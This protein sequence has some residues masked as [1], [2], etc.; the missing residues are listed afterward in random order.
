MAK[1][2]DEI[3]KLCHKRFKWWSDFESHNI[4]LFKGDLKFANG[5]SDNKWQWSQDNQAAR[6]NKP[7]LTVNKISQHNRQITNEARQNKPCIKYLPVDSG[8]DVKTAEILNGLVRHVEA[9]SNADLAYDT[10][11]EFAVDAG[12]GYWYIDTDYID[13]KTFDQEI[14]INTIDN[15]LNV[16]L[17]HRP[18]YAQDGSDAKWGMLFY[19]MPIDE[20]KDTYPKAKDEQG[21]E[22]GEVVENGWQDEKTIRL[23]K[24]YY[25][26]Y[27]DD[28][29]LANEQGILA[30][31]SDLKDAPPELIKGA[32]K[33]RKIRKPKITQ[34]L[35][36]GKTILETTVWPGKYIP[37]VRIVGSEKVIENKFERKGHTRPMKDP[38]VM[39]NYWTSAATEFVSMQGKQPYLAAYESI[40]GLEQYWSDMDTSNKPVLPFRAWDDEG[41]QLPMPKRQDPPI[42]A[43]AYIDGMQVASDEMK[44]TSGQYDATFGKNPNQ[45]SGVALNALQQ[46]G[47]IATFHFTD[48]KARA[49]R[50][51]GLIL[52]DL[53][54]KIYDVPTVK[55]IIG[56]DGKEDMVQLNPEQPESM[57]KQE[58]A[59]GSIKEIYNIGVGRFDVIVSTGAN[60]GTRRREAFAAMSEIAQRSPAI[61]EKA[62]DLLFKSADFPMAEEIADRLKPVGI[63]DDESIPPHIQQQ[64]QMMQQQLQ[65]MNMEMLK[66]DVDRY[67]KETDRLKAMLASMTPQQQQVMVNRLFGDIATPDSVQNMNAMQPAQPQAQEQPAQPPTPGIQ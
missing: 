50:F 29:L 47:D 1:K 52:L 44:A 34:C 61:M 12:L 45:Q 63:D 32:V 42:M 66:L 25:I 55:R 4:A 7:M 22:Q 10:A 43:Q 60:Y 59:D 67:A 31:K 41:R 16:A 49:I 14:Y 46:K 58:Q 48:N 24:Y 36:A 5:D 17:D 2:D 38:Q 35:I 8:A 20:F 30:F 9:N 64:M 13:D 21:W 3:V 33:R 6:K 18:G 28:E 62:G 40:A 19:D 23:A 11:D 27:E 53:F 26:E 15:P 39:Y 65:Q 51:T 54:P 57:Q 37:I 56:E